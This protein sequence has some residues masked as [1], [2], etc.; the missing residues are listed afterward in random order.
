[1]LFCVAF[2]QMCSDT[3]K[4][5]GFSVMSIQGGKIEALRLLSLINLEM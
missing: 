3:P 4:K 2:E 1:M 5:S